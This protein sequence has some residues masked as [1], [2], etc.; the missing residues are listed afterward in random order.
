MSNREGRVGKNN[1]MIFTILKDQLPVYVA[2]LLKR[3]GV[4]YT[5]SFIFCP[6][7]RKEDFALNY[8]KDQFPANGSIEIFICEL[9]SCLREQ[10]LHS[11]HIATGKDWSPLEHFICR[12]PGE[13]HDEAL[14]IAK[15]WAIYNLKFMETGD[16]SIEEADL[17]KFELDEDIQVFEVR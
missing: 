6:R 11:V 17:M 14:E 8:P 16:T 2:L 9:P 13:N 12:Y 15:F 5:F 4:T 7:E 1:K 3:K 10:D